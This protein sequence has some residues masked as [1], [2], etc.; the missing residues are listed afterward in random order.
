FEDTTR[1]VFRR[2]GYRNLRVPIVESTPLFVRAIGEVTDVVE[3]EMYTFDDRL[4]GESPTL[5]PEATAGIVRAAI[6]HNLTYDRP[7]RVWLAGP[8]FRHERPQKG[9]YRQFHQFDVEALG[10]SGPDVDVE[11]MV[12][13]ARLWRELGLADS[14]RLEIN[15]IGDAVERKA[16]RT[17]LIDYFSRHAD[18]LDDDSKRRLHTNP[19]RILDSKNPALQA[20]VAGAPKLLDRLGDASRAHFDE[21]KSLL[22]E[23]GIAYTINARLVRGLDY[24]NRTVFE[25][26]TDRLGAQGTVAG[27]GRYDGLFEQLGG[28]P[29]PAC[30]FGMGIERMI[31]LLQDAARDTASAPLAYVVHAGNAAAGPARAAAE[32]LRNAGHAVVVNAGGGSF[33]SQMKRADASGARYAVVVGDDEAAASSVA[34]KPL[35]DDGDQVAVPAANLV[36]YFESLVSSPSAGPPE[37]KSAHTNA[38]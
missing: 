29:T 13:L 9:R 24:Y 6:E 37:L 33:K 5:R 31:L 17:A 4:N 28:K 21:L 36:K 16:H 35:R 20:I 3:K 19:L 22:A 32:A 15:S 38:S 27:G 34:V 23:H 10:F 8:M 11:Q 14:I 26:V 7:Q 1:D 2:Y 25:F 30:G 12:M 18:V